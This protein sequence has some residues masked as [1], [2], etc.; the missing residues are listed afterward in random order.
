MS[1]RVGQRLRRD[2]GPEP[3]DHLLQR[4]VH[5]AASHD[6]IRVGLEP[7][8]LQLALHKPFDRTVAVGL[9][10]PARQDLAVADVSKR[11]V[12]KRAQRRWNVARERRGRGR[13]GPCTLARG[14][15]LVHRPH[16]VGE[17]P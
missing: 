14:R 12:G 8:R 5:V 3:L 13:F 9:E 4:L 2:R 1:E 10:R 6:R 7:S 16:H 15:R 11:A 17:H